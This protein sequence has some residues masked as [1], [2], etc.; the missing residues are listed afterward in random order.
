MVAAAVHEIEIDR[1]E[2]A[3][4]VVL[5]WGFFFSKMSQFGEMK[6]S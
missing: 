1:I 4:S 6:L 3:K 5:F 2:G